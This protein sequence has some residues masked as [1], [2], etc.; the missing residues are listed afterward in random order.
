[1]N[2]NETNY[3][4]K[5]D[6]EIG[7]HFLL[8]AKRMQELIAERNLNP[9]EFRAKEL[10]KIEG[11]EN[12]YEFHG[13]T[14]MS[15]SWSNYIKCIEQRTERI[16]IEWD[17]DYQITNKETGEKEIRRWYPYGLKYDENFEIE[18]INVEKRT[19]N[20]KYNVYSLD[21]S[22]YEDVKNFVISRIEAL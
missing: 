11:E 5:R 9:N 3:Y 14:L 1:M 12:T 4:A 15:M 17:C 20:S 7:L 10:N 18:K 19:V 8:K 13:S 21:P 16:E 22:V 2:Y 6:V